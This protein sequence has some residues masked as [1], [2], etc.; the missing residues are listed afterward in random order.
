MSGKRIRYDKCLLA[1]GGSP[2]SL[3]LISSNSNEAIRDR[4]SVFRSFDDF[5]K[6]ENTVQNCSKVV[7]VG[8]GYLGC[9]LSI[10]LANLK[11]S[12][13]LKVVQIIPE[14]GY[15]GLVL[16]PFLCRWVSKKVKAMGVSLQENA[17][18]SSVDTS[19]DKSQIE[20]TLNNGDKLTA[21]HVVIAVGIEP[22]TSLA[23][24]ANLEIDQDLGGI[25]VN[26]ELQ[27]SEP[28]I[29]VAGDACSFYD[30]RMNCRRRVEHHDHAVVSGRLAAKNML[31]SQALQM[32][33]KIPETNFEAFYHQSMFWGYLGAEI[34]Y[35]A[36]GI[37]DS[38]LP[39]KAYFKT[40]NGTVCVKSDFDTA[41]TDDLDLSQGV[42]FYLEPTSGE[43][44]R[45]SN[46]QR[47]VG[48]V[49]WNIFGKIPNARGLLGQEFL[50]SETDRL[51]TNFL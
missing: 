28:D 32:G 21:D 31:A 45:K 14:S 38:K 13:P 44:S 40:G 48:V 50:D 9:E 4:H 1:P 30:T 11:R 35:E 34:G 5:L 49:C 33:L 39:V 47:I 43:G 6:L 17:R 41:S 22:N 7:V 18:I 2:K 51:S 36:I 23:T 37:V 46:R 24:E 25:F 19:S 15:M 3:N 26:G 42:L 10:A 27:S 20:L 16:P 12:K 29:W 8:G